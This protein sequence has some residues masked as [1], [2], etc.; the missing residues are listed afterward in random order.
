MN[1]AEQINQMVDK[2]QP[3]ADQ[4]VEEVATRGICLMIIGFA[5]LGVSCVT[6]PLCL[7]YGARAEEK[8]IDGLRAI[9]TALASAVFL[10][11]SLCLIYQGLSAYLA[12]MATILG[13]K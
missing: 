6:I 8:S 3:V 13:I 2:L 12:P 7:K 9:L 5:M 1:T 11:A 10:P 4:I